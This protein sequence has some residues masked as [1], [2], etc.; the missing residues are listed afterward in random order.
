M[1]N[2]W[3]KSF[4]LALWSILLSTT[5]VVAQNLDNIDYTELSLEELL[6]VKVVTYT[7]AARKEQKLMDTAA[8]L[9][10]ITQ[11][12]IRRAGISSIPEAL[13][14][15]PGLEVARIDAHKWAI[16]AR[17]FNGMFA[18]KLLVMIDGRSVYTTLRSEVYWDV[19]DTVIDDI[20]RIEVIRGPGAS[21]WGANAV[22]GVIN[23]ITKSAHQT[24]GNLVTT[25]VGRNQERGIAEVQYGG[26]MGKGGHYRVY[27]KY[28]QHDGLVNVQ[29]LQQQDDWN[30]KRGG[31]RLD[32]NTSDRDALTVQGD[33]YTG[34]AKQL[35][36]ISRPA[37]TLVNDRIHLSGLNL[38]GRWKRNL[39]DGDIILQTYYDMTRRDE[40][41]YGDWRGTLDVDFQQRWQRNDRQEWIWGLGIRRTNDDLTNSATLIYTPP[42]RQDT[43]I[44]AFVQGEFKLFNQ[45]RLTLGSKFEQNDSSGFEIQPTV[46][47]LWNLEDHH[48][49]WAAVSKA[50]RTPSRTDEDAQL[51]LVIPDSA[52]I[53][54]LGNHDFESEELLAYELGYRF[55]PNKN[56][57]FDLSLFYNDYDK[58]RS[59][60]IIASQATSPLPTVTVKSDNQLYG[61]TYG[62]ELAT[63][64]Q[65][66]ETWKLIGTYSFLGMNL[67]LKAGSHSI[68][69]TS[70]EGDTPKHQA[71]VRSWWSLPYHTEVDT[72]L[73][74]VGNVPNQHTA[75][76]LR[77]DARFDWQPARY[78]ELSVGVRNLLDNQHREFG[79]GI[80][81]GLVMADEIQRAFYVQFKYRF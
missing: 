16:S 76:Y 78:F 27:S 15:V 33:A 21:L 79:S 75:S 4:V 71:N 9:F 20:D 28:Y 36:F 8:A 41:S 39:V 52:R 26:E 6:Q 7:A 23:I 5:T 35:V 1:K 60:E 58:L 10:V 67:H 3:L 68:L 49:L 18:S 37:A 53:I 12:D 73:Y 29:G 38:L 70:E 64:W 61:T 57:L 31:F 25:Q 30:L 2:I 80:S 48:S 44:S 74:Y 42:Q 24:Q 59:P 19:Q 62:L 63:T 51:T 56:L 45:L 13:R 40:I 81:G 46:R 66:K 14:M 65:V 32:W 34:L 22:N 54:A 50:V 69:G 17:G 43:L 77:V 55:N 72:A 47:L 11:E